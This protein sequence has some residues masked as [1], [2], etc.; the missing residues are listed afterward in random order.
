MGHLHHFDNLYDVAAG[1]IG[2]HRASATLSDGI[3]LDNAEPQAE[4]IAIKVHGILQARR[5]DR[6]MRQPNRQQFSRFF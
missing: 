2:H 5:H 1:R 3:I 4:D 6:R